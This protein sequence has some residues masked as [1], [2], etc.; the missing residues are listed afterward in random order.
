PAAGPASGAS[1][2]PARPTTAPAPC[3]ARAIA[4]PTPP[5]A[6]VTRAA[7]PVRSNIASS[8][9]PV[10][11]AC[12]AQP[13]SAPG[14]GDVLGRADGPRLRLLGDP[15]DHARKRLARA[16]LPEFV[17]ALRRHPFHRDRKSTRLNSS[18]VK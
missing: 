5:E 14:R 2:A 17:D 15:P 16:D 10:L 4:P 18:H 11:H 3:S 9:S 6:P 7:L 12:P 13:V 1:R 8:P